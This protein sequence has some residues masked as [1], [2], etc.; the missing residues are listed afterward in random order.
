MRRIGT[1]A[2]VIG[3]LAAAACADLDRPSRAATTPAE[4][5]VCWRPL[6][7]SGP[8]PYEYTLRRSDKR[9]CATRSAISDYEAKSD[10]ITD[11]CAE[12]ACYRDDGRSEFTPSLCTLYDRL[13]TYRTRRITLEERAIRHSAEHRAWVRRAKGGKYPLAMS[14]GFD[15]LALEEAEHCAWWHEELAASTERKRARR[16]HAARGVAEP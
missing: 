16:E 4:P 15:L 2:A 7:Q 14:Y 13:M 6:T 3:A 12:A 9:V 1:L 5:R 11:F 10:L 8:H